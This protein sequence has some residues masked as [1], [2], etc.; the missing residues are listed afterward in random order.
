MNATNP[1]LKEG[2]GRENSLYYSQKFMK[3]Y[4]PVWFLENY[5]IFIVYIHINQRFGGITDKKQ[6]TNS[7]WIK[8]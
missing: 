7:A 4:I 5:R 2:K 8:M 3:I 1:K 6:G